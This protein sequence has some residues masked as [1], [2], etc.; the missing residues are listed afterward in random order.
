MPRRIILL[1][2]KREVPFF[3]DYLLKRNPSLDIAAVFN[4]A[5]LRRAIKGREAESRII[6]FLTDVIV[7]GD[8]IEALTPVPYNIHPGP[9]AYPGS[10]PESFALWED[11][12]TYGVTAHE[13]TARVDE[14]AIIATSDF[15]IPEG[16]SR[17]ELADLAYA[18]AVDLFA[19]VGAHCAM[20][21]DPLPPNGE[22]WS[23]KKRTKKEFAD[24]IGEI[25]L[26]EPGRLSKLKR[27]L[28]PDY[29]EDAAA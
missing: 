27:V 22:V 24:L 3:S 1:T 28:G 12:K 26:A 29:K 4:A 6:A 25:P 15:A 11:A 2:G 14:G 7:P 18:R 10:H 19:F 9:P 20:S 21:D 17:I 23:G 16:C 5:D 13:M 8:V